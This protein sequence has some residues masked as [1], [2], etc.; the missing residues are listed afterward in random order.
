M[1]SIARSRTKA[2]PWV[3][4]LGLAALVAGVASAQAAGSGTGGVGS[5]GPASGE[6]GEL[7]PGCPNAQLG[8]RTL[9]LG[10]CGGD[11]ATLNWV[12]RAEGYGRPGLTDQFDA[13]TETAVERLQRNSGMRPSGVADPATAD[14][15]V[16]TMSAE[17]ASWYGP[18]FFGNR[19]ACGQKFTSR[20]LGVAHKTLE[21]GTRVVMRYRGRF[22][23]TTVIDR[24]PYVGNRQWDLSQ[25]TARALRFEGVGKVRVSTLPAP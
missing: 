12:L 17:L 1:A 14:A 21:C 16:A 9:E 4:A 19:T 25:A 10:D 20:I 2:A 22:V 11:V 18:G 15:L 7:T 3:A 13:A 8:R 24:G 6:E 23:R 5:G